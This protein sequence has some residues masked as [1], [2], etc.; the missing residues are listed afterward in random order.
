LAVVAGAIAVYL[1]GLPGGFVYDDHRLI[2]DNDGLKRPFDLRRSFLR[3]YYASDIDRIGL[4]Y[5]R[6]VALL[7]N[8]FDY[9]RGGGTPTA[10][11]VT[12]IVVHVACT[13]LLLLLAIRLLGAGPAA[14]ATALL[15]ALNPV[16]AE[17]VAF[18]SGRVDPLATMFGLGA[19]LCHLVANRATR[20][21]GWRAGVG[22]AWLFALLSKEIAFTV[23][24]VAFLL[25]SAEEGWPGWRA[26]ADR[27]PRYAPYAGAWVVYLPLRFVALGALLPPAA[28]GAKMVATRPPVVIG[29]YLAWLVMP[30]P[31]INLEPALATGLLAVG[32]AAVALAAVAAAV[33]LWRR[34]WRLEAALLAGC[35][36]TL[37][38]VAQL[39]PLETELS[40]RFLYFPSVA[41]ALLAGALV[42]RG[43]RGRLAPLVLGLVVV[44]AAVGAARL[45]PRSRV[46]RD[47]IALWEAKDRES[48]GSLKARLNLARTYAQRG[49]RASSLRAYDAAKALEP[50][51][52][53][54]LSAEI[55]ALTTDPGSEDYE[56]GLMKSLAAFPKDGALWNNLGFHLY[57]KGDLAGAR[58]AFAKSIELTP[59]RATAWLGMAMVRLGGGDLVG[60]DDAASHAEV[61]DPAL[62][63]ARALRVECALRL[64]KPCEALAMADGVALDDEAERATLAR[65]V[66]RARALCPR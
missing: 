49:D 48:G 36:V 2:V 4:G 66:A 65:V 54:G 6:P 51:L 50:S 42:R 55:S 24:V 64:G 39:K 27:F 8:E 14:Y 44:W 25:E 41:T 16:H 40:E 17:S 43:L 21:A 1:P 58:D 61:L 35:L 53:E 46:W 11:H 62:G 59:A 20:P 19:I 22:I 33:L 28:V 37:L 9:R 3:D 10:F 23:P 18:I 38:P 57:R 56:A 34:Q 15:F 45:V 52:A 5:Y 12:N 29:S 47:E 30:P 13:V 32:A 26:L 60:A 7:T 63:L 31:G